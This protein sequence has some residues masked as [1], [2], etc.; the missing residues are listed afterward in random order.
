MKINYKSDFDFTLDLKDCNGNDILYPQFDFIGKIYTQTKE[1][2]Y[3]FS[4]KDGVK[5]NCFIDNGKI[6]VVCKNHQLSVGNIKIEFLVLIKDELYLPDERKTYNVIPVDIELIQGNSCNTECQSVPV[7]VPVINSMK[8]MLR[9]QEQR[10]PIVH[11]AIK[12]FS[13]PGDKYFFHNT[14][15]IMFDTQDMYSCRLYVCSSIA[16]GENLIITIPN[17]WKEVYEKIEKYAQTLTISTGKGI[18]TDIDTL[19][20]SVPEFRNMIE[21]VD[22]SYCSE[23]RSPY[24]KIVDGKIR[25]LKPVFAKNITIENN[26]TVLKVLSKYAGRMKRYKI[27]VFLTGEKRTNRYIY[28][29]IRI[30][31]KRHNEQEIIYQRRR[32]LR[33]IFGKS[34]NS[35]IYRIYSSLRGKR[36]ECFSDFYFPVDGKILVRI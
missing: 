31:K 19:M 34:R 7:G 12:K 1:N 30:D 3:V 20:H 24:M 27:K 32:K 10:K 25:I 35:R 15:V 33:L 2:S 17:N 5:T 26:D 23:T 6:H 9:M 13:I 14:F 21:Y 36:S 29:K 16:G 22:E 28:H 4:I 18:L 8:Q 11:R